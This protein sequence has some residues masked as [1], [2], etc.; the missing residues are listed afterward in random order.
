MIFFI[1]FILADAEEREE[2]YPSLFS[3]ISSQVLPTAKNGDT[4]KE[5]D[6]LAP[7]RLAERVKRISEEIRRGKDEFV[8]VYKPP[9]DETVIPER[10]IVKKCLNAETDEQQGGRKEKVLLVVGATGAGKSTLVNGMVNYILGVEW[11]DSFRFKI[12]TEE[13]SSQAN[14]VTREITAYTIYPM[15]GS[16]IPYV[17]TVVDTPGFGD[18]EGLSR[19]T[20][21]THQIKEFFS[22][23]PPVGIDHLDGVGFVTQNALARLTQTQKHIFHSILSIF[24]KDVENNFFMMITFADGKNPPVLDAIEKAQITYDSFFKFNNSAPFADNSKGGFD[25]MFWQMGR[26]SFKDFFAKFSTTNSVSLQ[27]TNE[28]L[29]E[30]EQLE[31]LVEGLNPQ[32]KVGLAKIEEMDQEK[33]VLVKHEV[34]I[35]HNK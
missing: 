22:L 18:T 8:P 32:I 6:A 1:T 10:I 26:E 31:N 20:S 19:D 34:D 21:I 12:V 23:G 35:K 9:M 7:C 11:K 2:P 14:S 16:A 5:R 13:V 15:E 4:T 3:K 29:K 27:L 33:R 17:F 28:V 24:G 25:E 30:R